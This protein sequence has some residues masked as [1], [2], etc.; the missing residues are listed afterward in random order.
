MNYGST[1]IYSSQIQTVAEIFCLTL[2]EILLGIPMHKHSDDGSKMDE[3]VHHHMYELCE[4]CAEGK[5][6]GLPAS[7]RKEKTKVREKTREKPKEKE[8]KLGEKKV[9]IN[10]VN[11]KKG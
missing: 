5:C 7:K 11:Q 8:G 4:A 2:T 3:D 9:K 10:G 6:F 1:K